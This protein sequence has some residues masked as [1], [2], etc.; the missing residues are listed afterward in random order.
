MLKKI[1]ALLILGLVA[2]HGLAHAQVGLP[3]VYTCKTTSVTSASVPV[4]IMPSATMSTWTIHTRSGAAVSIL[5]FPYQG[6]LPGSAP[7]NVM[8]VAAGAI[9]T[10]Q[11]NLNTALGHQAVGES[12]AAVLASGSTAVTVDTCYR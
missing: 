1:P 10:D 7:S 5:A 11:I 4:Q 2:L 6:S 8:E 3:A 12:W 9:W